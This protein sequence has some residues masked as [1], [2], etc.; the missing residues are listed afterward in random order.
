[1]I[2]EIGKTPVWEGFWKVN[3]PTGNVT[4]ANHN[5]TKLI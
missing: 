1:M 2:Y 4:S 3:E 5:P